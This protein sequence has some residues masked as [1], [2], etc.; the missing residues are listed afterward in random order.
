MSDP[1]P[2]PLTERLFADADAGP[3]DPFALFEEWFGLA[4]A[5]EPNDPTAMALATV[6]AEGMPD[7]RMVLLNGRDGR[8]FC[9]FTNLES[10]K[11]LQLAARPNA[12]LLFHWKSLRRQ[13]R[14]RGPVEPVSAKEADAYFES[15]PRGSRIASSASDQSRPLGSRKALAARFEALSAEL[16]EGRVPRPPHWSGRRLVPLSIEF[17]RDGPFRLH[18][19]VRF[20]REAPGAAWSRTR[21]YP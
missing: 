11:G 10:E 2:E 1:V 18:D 19:R 7:A 14:L 15:R 21:L 8:G 3:L 6:D 5:S 20:S 4:V 12:A 13:V 17:W 9:F 16:G